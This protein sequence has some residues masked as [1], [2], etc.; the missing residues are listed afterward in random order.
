VSDVL[1][2]VLH[3][4]VCYVAAVP[5]LRGLYSASQSI[6]VG[7]CQLV[8]LLAGSPTHLS[9]MMLLANCLLPVMSHGCTAA[10]L[11]AASWRSV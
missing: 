4:Y 2:S 7:S 8:F 6:S 10:A 11:A 5:L 3:H 9:T 1:L